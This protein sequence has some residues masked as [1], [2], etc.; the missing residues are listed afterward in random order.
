M[1]SEMN[2]L[3]KEGT[4][5]EAS[6]EMSYFP[7][8]VGARWRRDFTIEVAQHF[9]RPGEITDL[10]V[11]LIIPIHHDNERQ[12]VELCKQMISIFNNIKQHE[13]I[14]A[15]EFAASVTG[16]NR[17]IRNLM[18]YKNDGWKKK[19]AEELN[20][21]W[22]CWRVKSPDTTTIYTYWEEEFG[23]ILTGVVLNGLHGKVVIEFS[24]RFADQ[25][26]L[27]D[28]TFRLID[29]HYY[30]AIQGTTKMAK[31]LKKQ[32]ERLEDL[33][34]PPQARSMFFKAQLLSIKPSKPYP[35]IKFSS[36]NWMISKLLRRKTNG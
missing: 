3:K 27:A 1:M 15:V 31:I 29:D 32:K 22:L 2:G 23:D 30:P 4:V 5:L 21:F 17:V 14:F 11:S 36:K 24:G 13:K 8:P 18:Q 9:R 12:H 10:Y 35:I 20:K 7:V 25:I 28:E 19:I 26:E 16:V 6:K 33:P 34:I